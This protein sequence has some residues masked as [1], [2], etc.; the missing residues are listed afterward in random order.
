MNLLFFANFL[1]S[2]SPKYGPWCTSTLL[3]PPVMDLNSILF[4]MYACFHFWM[5]YNNYWLRW[6]EHPELKPMG[7]REE[8]YGWESI[9]TCKVIFEEQMKV[10][11][12][13]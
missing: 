7:G 13:F 9:M 1:L 10:M 4:V 2:F 5:H 3:Y 12:E 6:E 8:E 11:V